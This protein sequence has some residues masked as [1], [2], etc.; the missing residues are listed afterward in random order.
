MKPLK[1]K[2]NKILKDLGLH[3]LQAYLTDKVQ[4]FNI[5]EEIVNQIGPADLAITSF[6]ISEEFIRSMRRL[7]KSQLINNVS[8]VIDSKAARKIF[9][10]IPFAYIVFDKLFFANNHS[11]VL[12]FKNEKWTVS[13]C[14]S[15]NQTRG[16][17]NESGIITTDKEI[18]SQFEKNIN[19]IIDR[20]VNVRNIYNP[21]I[22]ES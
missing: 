15:Q 13:I 14:T 12:L 8:L 11:K 4:L 2:N 17:R 5:V 18:F 21:D 16:N 10:L 1:C 7:K 22:I 6:S 20:S 9:K 19:N 3:P